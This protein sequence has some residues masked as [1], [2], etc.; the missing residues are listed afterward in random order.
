M[1]GRIKLSLMEYE[2]MQCSKSNGNFDATVAG[3]PAMF[4]G[5]KVWGY[6]GIR[7]TPPGGV[8]LLHSISMPVQQ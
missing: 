2:V 1:W 5:I 7:V 8:T 6:P 4:Q 3:H